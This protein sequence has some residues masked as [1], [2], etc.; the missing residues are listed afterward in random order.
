MD[1]FIY[2]LWIENLYITGS[3]TQY[4]PSSSCD[5]ACSYACATQGNEC[6]DNYEFTEYSVGNECDAF[7]CNTTNKGCVR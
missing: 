3:R 4:I 2:G 7:S 5:S 6:L 1:G